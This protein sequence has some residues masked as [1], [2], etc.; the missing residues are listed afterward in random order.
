MI[1]SKIVQIKVHPNH[2][3]YYKTL[4]PEINVG[5]IINIKPNELYVKST[6]KIEC[7]CEICGLN[8]FLEYRYYIKNTK[9]HNI[10]SCSQK[11]SK[12]KKEMTNIVKYGFKYHS[13]N[14]EVF[15]EKVK[16]TSNK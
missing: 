5:D 3:T 12:I 13:M 9:T 14:T 16:K 10:Y 11:C 6:T 4:Y 1:V 7:Q 2:L 15:N 8:K